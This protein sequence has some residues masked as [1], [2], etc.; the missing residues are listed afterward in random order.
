MMF[1]L[2]AQA[3]SISARVAVLPLTRCSV[4]AEDA[5]GNV[6]A[7]VGLYVGNIRPPVDAHEVPGTACVMRIVS[8]DIV[9]VEHTLRVVALAE[10]GI[11][12]DSYV[13][14]LSSV[15]RD[16]IAVELKL[17]ETLAGEVGMNEGGRVGMLLATEPVPS[18][19][20]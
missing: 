11:E 9:A 7:K 20:V 1:P 15:I 17:N 8:T 4:H 14:V 12:A 3:V 16:A 18:G 13:A 6:V 10:M 19:A 2:L 5:A